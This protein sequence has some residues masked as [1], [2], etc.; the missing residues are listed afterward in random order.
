MK[1]N[2]VKGTVTRMLL[3]VTLL[4]GIVV[5]TGP[6]VQA[7]GRNRFDRGRVHPRRVFVSPRRWYWHDRWYWNDYPYNYQSF[8]FPST[9][10]TEGQGYRD[11]LNDGKDDVK[12]RK[13]NDPYRHKDYKNAVTSAYISGYLRG[14]AE[15]YRQVDVNE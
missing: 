10:V 5:L 4:F 14:Y 6:T 7:Q 9:H 12:D 8:Y 15:G 11:G 13:A 2:R 1:M 3:V